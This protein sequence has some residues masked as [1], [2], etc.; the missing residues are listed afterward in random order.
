MRETLLALW[1]LCLPGVLQ[2]QEVSLLA[3]KLKV[4]DNDERSFGANLSYTYKLG[5]H[6]AAS[7]S[8]LN[9]GHPPL[10]HRDGLSSQLW[11]RTREPIQDLSFAAGIG[12]YFY[13]D[14]TTGSGS[15]TDYRNEHGW[16]AL[17]T[18]SAKWHFA[19]H[20]FVQLQGN[21]IYVRNQHDTSMLL[22]GIGY[23]LQTP[24]VDATRLNVT[25]G[26]NIFILSA[27][28]AIINSFE[29]ERSGATALEYRRTLSQYAEWSVGWLNE[30]SVLGTRRKGVAA[31]LW[32][33]RPLAERV[34]LQFGGGLY[35]M[36]DHLE[37]TN[38]DRGARARLAL[39]ASIGVRYRLSPRW[40]AQLTWSRV[41]T[42][43][44]RDA[45]VFLLGFGAAL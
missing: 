25:P 37:H 41:I 10:H 36:T 42:D 32:L 2:A 24:A 45:D 8:Y 1:I 26:D 43:Y 20:W 18:L 40:R 27:G 14:T 19:Q 33:V 16:G 34:V 44:H 15:A 3:G 13:F 5:E 11:L 6:G 9:E 17:A 7:F 4:Q 31:Q 30:G 28:R 22:L 39:L 12:P 35:P 23:E 29:S 21:R 38:V